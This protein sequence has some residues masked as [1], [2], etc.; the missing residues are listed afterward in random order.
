MMKKDDGD[1][2]AAF[3]VNTSL[4]TFLLT[5]FKATAIWLYWIIIL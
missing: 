1:K 4:I 3:S 2:N 5:F